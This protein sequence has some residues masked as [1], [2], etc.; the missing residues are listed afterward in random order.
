MRKPPR[1]ALRLPRYTIRKP[2]RSGGWAYFFQVPYWARKKG[3]PVESE[4]L[5]MDYEAAVLR[6]ET[7]LLPAFDSWRSGGD[8]AKPGVGILPGTLDWLF[9]EFRKTWPHPTAKRLRPL[10]PGQCRVHETGIKM[11]SEYT[12]QNGKRLGSQRLSTFDSAV[13]EDL[14]EKLLFKDVNGE[15]IERRTT[16]G[17]TMVERKVHRRPRRPKTIRKS[18]VG[19]LIQLLDGRILLDTRKRGSSGKREIFATLAE[20]EA[21]LRQ[22]SGETA[23]PAPNAAATFGECL[24]I[25]RTRPRERRLTKGSRDGLESALRR[26][27]EEFGAWTLKGLVEAELRPIQDFFSQR[28]SEGGSTGRGKFLLALI[29]QAFKIGF[30]KGWFSFNPLDKFEVVVPFKQRQDRRTL[31]IAEISAMA[32]AALLR[33]RQDRLEITWS[34]RQLMFFL[35]LLTPMRNE[36]VA[37]LCW[38][39]LDMVHRTFLIKRIVREGDDGRFELVDDTKTGKSGV[40]QAPMPPFLIPLIEAHR[41]RLL[42]RGMPVAGRVPLLVPGQRLGNGMVSPME[43]TRGHLPALTAKAGLSLPKGLA[44]YVMR[45]T[46]TNLLKSVGMDRDDLLELGGWT[47]SKVFDA[48][49]R[50]ATPEYKQALRPEVEAMAHRLGLDLKSPAGVV[51]A[52]GYVLVARWHHEGISLKMAPHRERPKSPLEAALL[53]VEHEIPMLALPPPSAEDTTPTFPSVEAVRRWQIGEAVRLFREEGWTRTRIAEHLHV[54]GSTIGKWLREADIPH[55]RGLKGITREAR[56]EQKRK[57]HEIRL[58]NPKWGAEEIGRAIGERPSTVSRWELK[59]GVPVRRKMP[60]YR[61]AEHEATIRAMLAAG[62]TYVDVSAATRLSVGT[63]RTFAKEL[64]LKS[65]EAERQGGARA[66]TEELY[67]AP[68]KSDEKAKPQKGT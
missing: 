38:D 41:D 65:K 40:R 59:R 44:F 18:K 15:K 53:G 11:L 39:C 52:L 49:Y 14:F 20:A 31:T 45:H 36:E 24:E 67:T 43:I 26:L 3:C 54:D 47:D 33:T 12:L 37:G 2:L 28:A 66:E 50:H 61:A 21:R 4:P 60:R 55:T 35:A 30:A 25:M 13:A 57:L 34:N 10:S 7:V 27:Q 17:R 48:H 46:A 23:V 68:P 62:R 19:N 58:A 29:A 1:T 32:R 5:E 8:D 16:A 6:A 51:D 9:H 64:G 22:I 63:V 42:A 56:A